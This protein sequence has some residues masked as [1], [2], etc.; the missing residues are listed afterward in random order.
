M[1]HSC[2]HMDA[3]HPGNLTQMHVAFQLKTCTVMNLSNS[4]SATTFSSNRLPIILLL[5]T[6]WT[7]WSVDP[8]IHGL[9]IRASVDWQENV[10]QIKPP[11]N[12]GSLKFYGIVLFG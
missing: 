8:W 5:I 3:E 12:F 1:R 10:F 4:R 6:D 9:S 2:L 7:K 11:Q